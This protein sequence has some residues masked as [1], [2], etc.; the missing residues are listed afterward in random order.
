M[1]VLVC[2]SRGWTD[3]RAVNERVRALPAGTIV[4]EGG[5]DGADTFAREAAEGRGLFVADVPVKSPHWAL[6]GRGAGHRRN[7]AMLALGPDLVIA[8]Q[9]N[10]SSGT[11]GTIDEARRRGISVEVHDHE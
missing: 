3:R 8:F 11:Q 7:A 10:R 6:H 4:I 9:R 1:K 2:G 5:A